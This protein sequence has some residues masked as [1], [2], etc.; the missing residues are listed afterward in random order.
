MGYIFMKGPS[1]LCTHV[2]IFQYNDSDD[3]SDEI[4]FCRS[5]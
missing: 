2:Y 5:E 1:E 3:N 4:Y